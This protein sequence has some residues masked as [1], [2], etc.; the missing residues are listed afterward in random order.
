MK[1]FWTIMVAVGT[2]C[3]N[4]D[5]FVELEWVGFDNTEIKGEKK[6]DMVPMIPRIRGSPV[7]WMH[8]VFQMIPV[9]SSTVHSCF[10]FILFPQ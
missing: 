9:S 4:L 3:S 5:H 8:K 10:L 7:G 2:R 6:N 1:V